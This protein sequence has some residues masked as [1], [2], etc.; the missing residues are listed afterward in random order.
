MD[1]GFA[2]LETVRAADGRLLD[3]IY[4]EVND[5]FK[6][7]TGF[8]AYDGLRVRKIMPNIEDEW[9]AFYDRVNLNGGPERRVQ[10]G[11]RALV[12]DERHA[13]WPAW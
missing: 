7:L 10:H 4:R 8:E 12:S 13:P 6:R 2:V 3:L 1:A 5:A 11:Y 9:L